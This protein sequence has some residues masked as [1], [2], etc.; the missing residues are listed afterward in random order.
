[1]PT[2]RETKYCRNVVLKF[3]APKNVGTKHIM[4][5]FLVH[6]SFYYIFRAR[7]KREWMWQLIS[8]VRITSTLKYGRRLPNNV[9]WTCGSWIF[10]W[11]SLKETAMFTGQRFRKRRSTATTVWNRSKF[12][13]MER[14]IRCVLCTA[15]FNRIINLTSMYVAE[16]ST[17]RQGTS[18]KYYRTIATQHRLIF[19]P[20][21]L[22]TILSNMYTPLVN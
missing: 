18:P 12:F 15:L 16:F 9:L 6:H 21:R 11:F 20:Y 1:M 10:R 8:A 7:R 2:G 17:E 5:D 19:K 22:Q 13:L 14:P 4:G 3:K